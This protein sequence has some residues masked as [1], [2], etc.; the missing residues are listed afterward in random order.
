[1][2]I[3]VLRVVLS[4]RERPEAVADLPGPTAEATLTK[5]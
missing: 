5:A 1:M 2:W 4:L 3:W